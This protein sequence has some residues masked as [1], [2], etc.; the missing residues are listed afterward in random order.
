ML[1]VKFKVHFIVCVERRG[2]ILYLSEFSQ[3][4][5]RHCRRTSLKCTQTHNNEQQD[6]S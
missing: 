6:V 2:E 3:G 1:P 5:V 4:Y